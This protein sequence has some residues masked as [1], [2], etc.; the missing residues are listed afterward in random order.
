[1]KEYKYTYKFRGFSLYCQPTK[2][3]IRKENNKNYK[4]EIIVYDRK[5]TENE[6]NEY[7]LIELS[8]NT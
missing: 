1:M 4:F 5:L 8:K 3:F 7:E 2:G 6:I